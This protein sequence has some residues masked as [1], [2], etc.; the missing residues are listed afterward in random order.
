MSYNS[1]YKISVIVPV[2]NIA[3]Y[4]PRSLDSIL[5]QTHK[6][7]EVIVIDDGSSD[8]SGDIIREYEKKDSRVKGIFKE[9]SGVSD[10]RNAGIELATGDYMS[11]VD[12]DDY[13]EP[14]MLEY[15]LENA[16][17]YGADISHCGYQ[18]VF[19]SRVD[20]YYNTGKLMVQ[21]NRQ[22]ISDLIK[23]ELV[24]PGIW[25][26]LYKRE[27]IGDVRMP[28]DI[29]I[30]EDYLFNVEVF[31]NSEKSVFED[32]PFYHYILR[33]N[34]AA[35]SALS[36][37]KLFDGITVRE[38]I[39]KIFENDEEMYRLALVGLLKH[40]VN[41]YRTL[42][43]NKAA[44]MFS[45]RKKEV[46][47]NIRKQFKKSKELG[48]ADKRTS[49]DCFLIFYFPPLYKLLYKIYFSITKIDRKYE[50]K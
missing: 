21:D 24:E 7:I 46:K 3:E 28:S 29:R 37:K 17:K 1:K 30:N 15:L 34:S 43:L 20:Y 2:Y 44:K 12:G 13:I 14:D 41:L 19:P 25:N 48:I 50:V 16:L 47:E 18:M 38:R 23:G 26:K 32:K 42:V 36:E 40:N 5:S 33:E 27:V 22:G 10:T 11:F 8:G 31:L 45:H 9:N 4:L 39:L 6:N 35:T 49:L